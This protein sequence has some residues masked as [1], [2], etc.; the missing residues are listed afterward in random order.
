MRLALSLLLVLAACS[1]APA[2]PKVLLKEWL[3]VIRRQESVRFTVRI[4]VE[5]RDPRRR[6]F[7]GVRR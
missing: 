7:A 3:D 2:D 6:T 4:E 5:G 1:P